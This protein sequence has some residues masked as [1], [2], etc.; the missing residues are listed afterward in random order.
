MVKGHQQQCTYLFPIQ[1]T[2]QYSKQMAKMLSFHWEVLGGVVYRSGHV[3]LE[4]LNFSVD[5]V[6]LMKPLHVIF[7]KYLH[8]SH[9]T[10][11]M[12]PCFCYL[13]PVAQRIRSP[14]KMKERLRNNRI[15][16]PEN[17]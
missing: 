11:Q 14:L 2:K 6:T 1:L 4:G 16:S 8:A 3:T 12:R 7:S 15:E 10:S 9:H 5:M 13:V 17:G